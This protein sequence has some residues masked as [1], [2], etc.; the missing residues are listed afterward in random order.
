MLRG[1]I[2]VLSQDVHAVRRTANNVIREGNILGGCPWCR[3]ILVLDFEVDCIPRLRLGPVVFKRISVNEHAARILEFQQ[4][5]DRPQGARI[6]GIIA[7]P[8]EGL[9]EEVFSDLNVRR[10]EVGNS[11][12]SPPKHEVLPGRLQ[13]IIRDAKWPSSIPP[14]KGLGVLPHSLDV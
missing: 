2:G 9:A 14:T 1:L 3:A 8:G 6:A 11:W 13:V 10:D 5:F 4:V 7:L 12:V